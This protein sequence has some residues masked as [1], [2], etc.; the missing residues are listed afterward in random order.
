ML[1]RS[2]RANRLH[3]GDKIVIHNPKGKD[4]TSILNEVHINKDR[5]L[6]VYKDR[7]AEGFVRFV[8][9]TKKPLHKVRIK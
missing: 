8:R 6:I 2:V 3:A 5:V 1:S 4:H 7:D 9:E